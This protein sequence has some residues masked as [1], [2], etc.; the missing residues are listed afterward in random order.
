MEI[1]KADKF[2]TVSI[3]ST[4]FNFSKKTVLLIEKKSVKGQ[5]YGTLNRVYRVALLEFKIFPQWTLA[6]SSVPSIY[7]V[8]LGLGKSSMEDLI[9]DEVK[10]MLQDL[11]DRLKESE[12]VDILQVFNLPIINSLWKIITGK[13]LDM[14][15][16]DEKKKM[17]DLAEMF[18]TFGALNITRILAFRYDLF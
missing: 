1:F 5:M 3:K 10:E 6:K 18:A 2:C 16:P 17:D 12:Q 13:R 14:K 8:V 7:I 11:K 4:V 15:N 9:S